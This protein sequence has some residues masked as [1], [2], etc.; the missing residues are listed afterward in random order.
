MNY[1]VKTIPKFDKQIKQL[2]KKYP[3][4]K[5]DFIAFVNSLKENPTQ[6]ILLGNSCYKIRLA[7]TGKNKG[8]SNGARII[9]HCIVSENTAYLISIYDKS[10]HNTI[11]DN[12]IKNLL[13][14]ISE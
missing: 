12:E 7:I 8:K 13:K 5:T 3:S 9:T 6:G 11:S 2:V 10:E 14:E 1:S 4:F